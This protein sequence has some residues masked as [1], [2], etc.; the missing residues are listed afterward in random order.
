M[1]YAENFN[2]V[3]SIVNNPTDLRLI[4]DIIT[5]CKK[6]DVITNINTL[7]VNETHLFYDNTKSQFVEA[8]FKRFLSRFDIPARFI[9]K[10]PD[11][12]SIPL[13]NN[14]LSYQNQRNNSKILIRL[15]DSKIRAILSDSYI[16]I[17]DDVI[18]NILESNFIDKIQ[19][20]LYYSNLEYSRFSLTTKRTY[21]ITYG[22][23]K[24]SMELLVLNNEV[25]DASVR[26]G[27]TINIENLT[28]NTKIQFDIATDYRL[29]G[30]VIHRGEI[31]TR[32]VN[33]LNTLFNKADENWD[34]IIKA[35]NLLNDVTL[36]DLES[37]ENKMLTVLKKMPEYENWK[38]QYD[39][40]RKATVISNAFDLL[41]AITSIPNKQE[42]YDNLM[43]NII[44]GSIF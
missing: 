37:L 6:S 16:S 3:S 5:D 44:Y 38:I 31:Q 33:L 1:K 26:A 7:S 18:T 2:A 28:N 23:Y 39:V 43:S 15:V 30:R 29:L 10:Q 25:G 27:L 35:L 36:D 21:S 20:I 34:I 4:K 8:G 22:N 19:Q 17:D 11:W 12:I 32:L 9:L 24:A 40:M 41:Y 42:Y 13:I 14:V